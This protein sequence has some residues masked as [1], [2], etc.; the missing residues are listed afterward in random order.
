MYVHS[1]FFVA[2]YVIKHVACGWDF[3]LKP[4][5]WDIGTI[6]FLVSDIYCEILLFFYEEIMLPY[7]MEG[8]VLGNVLLNKPLVRASPAAAPIANH[9]SNWYPDI[10]TS[11]GG[12]HRSGQG[13]FYPHP[14]APSPTFG[15]G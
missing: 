10:L 3:R 14:F 2:S 9:W 12:P 8:I 15:A 6:L 13:I 4:I 5:N 1:Y 7:V 11:N